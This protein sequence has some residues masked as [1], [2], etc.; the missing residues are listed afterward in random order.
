M[1][2]ITLTYENPVETKSMA[3]FEIGN[4]IF[5]FFGLDLTTARLISTVA[6]HAQ[7]TG[8]KIGYDEAISDVGAMIDRME[9]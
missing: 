4:Q 9:Y 8:H 1:N 5:T 7:K 2:P 3:R 6:N